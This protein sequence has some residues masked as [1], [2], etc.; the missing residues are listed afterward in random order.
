ME[1]E[2]ITQGGVRPVTP[3]TPGKRVSAG[4]SEEI[5]AT[6]SAKD[7]SPQKENPAQ[8]AKAARERGMLTPEEAKKA[9]EGFNALLKPTHSHLRFLYHEKMGEYYVQIIDD[10][11]NEVIREIPPKKLLDM[12]A[13]IWEQIGLIVDKRI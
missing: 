7:T 4:T 6:S 12:V 2:R 1:I 5:P 8:D 10:H 9:V 11:N 13:A 3:I